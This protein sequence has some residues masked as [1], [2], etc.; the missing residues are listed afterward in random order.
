MNAQMVM[1]A[2]L[3]AVALSNMIH[4]AVMSRVQMEHGYDVA[5]AFAVMSSI[6]GMSVLILSE[7]MRL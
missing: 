2:G 3:L 5:S 6:C 4:I 7:L 1:A